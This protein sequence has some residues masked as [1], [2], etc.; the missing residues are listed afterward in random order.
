MQ[1]GVIGEKMRG[2]V[3]PPCVKLRRRVLEMPGL[4]CGVGRLKPAF[5]FIQFTRPDQRN[6]EESP[7]NYQNAYIFHK[8]FFDFAP[9]R[10]NAK[11]I[12]KIPLASLR[13]GAKNTD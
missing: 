5:R 4:V 13:L 10:K 2:K 1:F 8:K 3:A 11:D 6:H 12:W 9:R 7:T